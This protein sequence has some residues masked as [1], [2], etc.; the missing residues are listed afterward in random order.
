M[1]IVK[2]ERERAPV[3][4]T[5]RLTAKAEDGSGTQDRERDT[6]KQ[7]CSQRE[8]QSRVEMVYEAD[9]QIFL[10]ACRYS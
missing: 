4:Q 3:T 8:R 6:E 5:E 9:T 1:Q 7:N 2:A 10:F